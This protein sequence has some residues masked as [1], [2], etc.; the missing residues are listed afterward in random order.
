M[1]ST[2]ASLNPADIVAKPKAKPGRPKGSRKEDTRARLLTVARKHFAERGLALTTFKDVG[3]DLGLSH[4]AIYQYYGSKI[5]LYKATL[6]ATQALL[7][8]QYMQAIER[9]NNLRERITGVLM[10]SADAHDKDSTITGMLASVPI[11]MRRHPELAEHFKLDDD[12]I[13][14]SLIAM[15]DEA[16]ANGEIVSKASSAHLVNAFLGGGVGVAIFQYGLQTSSLRE[17]MEVYVALIEAQIF[18]A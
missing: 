16:K 10:A 11:E 15:F 18:A 3:K 17:A 1:K 6:A 13:M 4:A 2:S 7:L 8:P 5:E 12:A 9:G 14:M